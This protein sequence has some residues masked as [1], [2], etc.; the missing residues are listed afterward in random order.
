M[1]YL[2]RLSSSNACSSVVSDLSKYTF[3]V[4]GFLDLRVALYN[5]TPSD[6]VHDSTSALRADCNLSHFSGCCPMLFESECGHSILCILQARVEVHRFRI[7]R[8]RYDVRSDDVGLA[9]SMPIQ[10]IWYL[11]YYF[12]F[13]Y[14]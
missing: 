11:M 7:K 4:G 5:E 3:Q 6:T 1:W 14:L 2:I 13:D 12:S 8:I 9:S 10:K